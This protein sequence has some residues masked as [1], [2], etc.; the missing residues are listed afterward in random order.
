MSMFQTHLDEAIASLLNEPDQWQIDRYTAVNGVRGIE[1]W[2]AN[3]PYAIKLTVG[4]AH[5]DGGGVIGTF[6]GW[7]IPWR[8]NLCNAVDR[9]SDRQRQNRILEK[10]RGEPPHAESSG[11]WP[12]SVRSR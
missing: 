2:H 6:F 3:R 4:S 12:L 8:R 11:M 10:A 7:V 5:Y 1:I 9:C